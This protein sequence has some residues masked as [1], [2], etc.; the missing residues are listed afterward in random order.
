LLTAEMNV[1]NHVQATVKVVNGLGYFAVFP[2]PVV[3][4]LEQAQVG[5]RAL[6][7]LVG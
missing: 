5:Y 7:R 6:G 3:L 1:I 4:Y 2:I